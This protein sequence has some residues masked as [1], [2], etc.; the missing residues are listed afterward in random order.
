MSENLGKKFEKQV[1]KDM[2]KID[3]VSVDRIHDQTNGHYGGSNICDYMVYKYPILFY[4][5][6][7]SCGGNTLSIH[8]IPKK[9]KHGIFHGFYGN[10][11]DKQWEGLSKKSRIKGVVAGVLVWYTERDLTYFIPITDLVALRERGAKSVNCKTL[12][13]DCPNAL[14]IKAEKKRVF[15]NYDFSELLGGYYE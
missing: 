9:D 1:E 11:S 5:E 2:L 12:E 6:C 4:I 3:E 8:S 10:I 7:K 15:F 14:K 13:A